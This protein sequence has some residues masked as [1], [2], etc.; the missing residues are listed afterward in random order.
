MTQRYRGMQK[1]VV[2][3]NY[4]CCLICLSNFNV[5]CAPILWLTIQLCKVEQMGVKYR[6]EVNLRSVY[7]AEF[8]LLTVMYTM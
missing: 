1:T 3:L 5:H 4:C 6:Y 7:P 2:E 8:E